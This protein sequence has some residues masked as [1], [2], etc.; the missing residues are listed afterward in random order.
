L[1]LQLL[2]VSIV[3]ASFGNNLKRPIDSD[4]EFQLPKQMQQSSFGNNEKRPIDSEM[5]FQPPKQ[6]QHTSFGNNKKRPFDSFQSPKQMQH[7]SFDNNKKRRFD[8]D[9]EF[10]PPKQRQRMGLSHF[11]PMGAS[12]TKMRSLLT[13]SWQQ[14]ARSARPMSRLFPTTMEPAA[15]RSTNYVAAAPSNDAG[16]PRST[17]PRSTGDSP[18]DSKDYY[19]R[20]IKDLMLDVVSNCLTQRSLPLR[21]SD[22]RP[23]YVTSH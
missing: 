7:T 11:S 19:K 3:A 21:S 10:Q 6:M 9:L 8:S 23:S 5:K 4:L 13:Q 20:Q 15:T 16:S 1:H 2:H 22:Y 18:L 12:S 14:V 17:S